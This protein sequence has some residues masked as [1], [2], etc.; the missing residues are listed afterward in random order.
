MRVKDIL[1]KFT[2]IND[3]ES[4]S[5]FNFVI[6]CEH[7]NMPILND[8]KVIV[9]NGQ[10]RTGLSGAACETPV[11]RNKFYIILNGVN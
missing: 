10:A 1:F 8:T 4:D 2:L 7:R 5:V 11:G 6:K 3:N 9:H